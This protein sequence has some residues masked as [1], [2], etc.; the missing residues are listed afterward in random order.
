MQR[1]YVLFDLD[2]TLIY[3]N[4]YFIKA[5]TLYLDMMMDLFAAYPVRREEIK[6]LQERND[7]QGVK[8]YGLGKHRFADSLVVTYRQLCRRFGRQ[9]VP[10]EEAALRAI[11]YQ[12][13][14]Q[15]AELYPHAMQTL[16]SL[17][18]S[19]HE[20]FLYSG[21]DVAIQ[22]EKVKKA[23]LER[24]FPRQ[25]CFIHLHKN[26]STLRRM[27]QEHAWPP[28]R[29]WMVG[30][31]ARSDIRPALELGLHAIHIPAADGWVYDQA[32][33]DVHT[34]GNLYVLPSLERVPLIIEQWA[35]ETAEEK[36]LHWK[37][38]DMAY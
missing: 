18:R 2:D 16:E 34:G 28:H 31:S 30:N 17:Q 7:L 6:E 38:I 35:K 1:Q 14:Q 8:R 37:Q 27:I 21:G 10:R 23:G 32:D 9:P 19:G 13:Y 33:L 12:V 22:M 5:R 3:C 36:V 20:L 4:R 24:F 11:G 26:V 25:R 15:P 29:T